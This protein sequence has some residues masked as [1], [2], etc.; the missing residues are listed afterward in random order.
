MKLLHRNDRVQNHLYVKMPGRW[1]CTLVFQNPS[2]TF[3][4]VHPYVPTAFLFL[5]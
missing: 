5:A 2:N 4:T 3:A 1:G